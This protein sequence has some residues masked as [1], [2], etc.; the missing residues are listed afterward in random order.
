MSE[1]TTRYGATTLAVLALLGAACGGTSDSTSIPRALRERARTEEVVPFDGFSVPGLRLYRAS[2]S[3]PDH[4]WSSVVGIDADG[5]LVEDAALMRRLGPLEPQV[6]AERAIAIV[7]AEAGQVPLQP[8]DERDQFASEQ[9]WSVV[10]SPR[11]EGDR[12]VFFLM[13]GEM[14][15]SLTEI[16]IDAS[17]FRP[18]FRPAEQVLLSLGREALIGTPICEALADCGCWYDCVPM[19]RYRT[20]GSDAVHF[21][22]ATGEDTRAYV[23]GRACD[24]GDGCLRVCR[25]DAPTAYC[26]PGLVLET[27]SSACEEACPLGEAPFHCETLV[28]G[29]R[30]VDH[31]IRMHR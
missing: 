10:Q 7:L 11:R 23:L 19:Q 13:M 5:H 28:N 12:V 22:R 14:H 15:P 3:V 6:F 20:P 1:T 25:A 17:T 16:R 26:D 2:G 24:S 27:G 29:C 9:E 4:G 21:R 8:T 30:K 31:P 18:E